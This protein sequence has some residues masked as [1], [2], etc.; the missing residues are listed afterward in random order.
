MLREDVVAAVQEGRFRIW[1]VDN[2]EQGIEALT[3]VPAGEQRPDGTYAEGTVNHLVQKRLQQYADLL[4][5]QAGPA[6]E[7]TKKD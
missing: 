7:G 1:A 4:R 3:G 2:V 6:P 5:S